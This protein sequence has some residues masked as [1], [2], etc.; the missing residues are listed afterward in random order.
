MAFLRNLL[1]T[2]VGLI[3]FT[4]LGIFIFA[5]IISGLSTEEVPTV[6]ENSVLY[7]R[8]GGVVQERTVEDPLQE[9]LPASAPQPLGLMDI[10][11]A[12]RNA[13]EDEKIK[14][15]YMEHQFLAAGY[16]SLEE[17]REA[18]MDF[19]S[20]GKFLY[21]YGEFI[22]E[23][24]YYL[25][26]V[27]DSIIMHPEGSL[28]FNGL[29]VSV[30]FWKGL[31]EKL[32]IEPVIFRVGE[33]KSA[34][35]PFMKKEMSPENRLQLTELLNSIYGHYLEKTSEARGVDRKDLETASNDLLVQLPNDAVDFGLVHRLGYEDE[36][37][38]A[39]RT[40]LGLDEGDDINFISLGRYNK[41]TGA[42]EYSKNKVAVIF[43]EGN[44]VAA[45]DE[46]TSIV[47]DKL[48]NEIRKARENSSIK[49]IVLRVNSPGGSLTASDAIWREVKKTKGVKPII[50]SMSDVAASGGYY[51]AMACDSIVAQPN[52]ITGSIGIFGLLF[53]FED[54]LEDKLGITSENVNTGKHSD[55]MTVTRELTDYERQ[56][57]QKNVEKGYDTFITKAAEGRGLTTEDIKKVA[58]GRVWSGKQ[59]LDNKLI[60]KLGSFDDAIE[61]AARMAGVEDDYR[62][63]FYPRKKPLIEELLTQMSDEAEVRIFGGQDDILGAYRE[64]IQQL[65]QMKGV[66]AIMPW[67]LEIK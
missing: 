14:G 65:N 48:A 7:L 19:K 25:A 24:D 23:G 58:G 64:K 38:A 10:L 47:G 40:N 52:T 1:A 13:K 20:S 18:L 16:A 28:E 9:L 2:L 43:G 30:T 46:N 12:I 27:A 44:I 22:S 39:I 6:K 59:A 49:A 54:F 55:Y 37:K 32:K 45:G 5:G 63:S 15:I 4:F 66:Q 60:D 26:A 62:V 34:V 29:T 31:F 56:V 50:A 51:I 53:N 33:F 61:M 3:I 67:N 21:S 36:V 8:M 57:I 17:I 42:G 35:E 11:K 41:A